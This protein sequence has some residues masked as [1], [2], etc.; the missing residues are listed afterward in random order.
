MESETQTLLQAIEAVFQDPGL[1]ELSKK[2]HEDLE[3][4]NSIAYANLVL[5]VYVFHTLQK[6]QTAVLTFVLT[7]T[8]DDIAAKLSKSNE[9]TAYLRTNQLTAY[10]PN[11]TTFSLNEILPRFFGFDTL[12]DI[13]YFSSIRKLV[14]TILNK[15]DAEMNKLL[16]GVHVHRFDW[17]NFY[18]EV[19]SEGMPSVI[20]ANEH[21]LILPVTTLQDSTLG[22]YLLDNDDYKERIFQNFSPDYLKQT[23][24]TDPTL[25]V[26]SR[27]IITLS[28]NLD[29]IFKNI[30]EASE[31]TKLEKKL[32]FQAQ[33]GTLDIE[34]FNA[35]VKQYSASGL[36][37][38]EQL[39]N[40]H[41]ALRH[42]LS[43][44]YA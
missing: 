31:L 42:R 4:K 15:L 5:T 35:A 3:T 2:L 40:C 11:D 41:H 13:E 6:K 16:Y 25:R 24:F 44:N 34:T 12:T 1:L 23:V 21:N 8:K 33:A 7:H 14:E 18:K 43:T 20:Y 29:L 26:L 37:H 17:V 36:H 10:N 9:F 39:N 32:T 19:A 38:N 30:P 22:T 27:I 28:S